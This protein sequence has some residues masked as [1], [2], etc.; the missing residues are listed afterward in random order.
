[1]GSKLSDY[2]NIVARELF[3]DPDIS[4]EDI[5]RVLNEEKKLELD[6][7]KIQEYKR[8]VSK[9]KSVC[10][11]KIDRGL[12]ALAD[13]LRL[14]YSIQGRTK[15]DREKDKKKEEILRK[16]GILRGYDFRS[17]RIVYVFYSTSKQEYSH[18]PD[19]VCTEQCEDQC[20]DDLRLIREEHS[21]GK[22]GK[23]SIRIQFI[24]TIEEII[25]RNKDRDNYE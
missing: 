21:L 23:D 19:H 16:N 3:K 22:P 11:K 4:L 9:Y 18:W 14:D 10:L 17:D 5:A 20:L 2:E 25:E 6:S 1:M 13:V 24:K 15:E 12:E 8:P 7:Q